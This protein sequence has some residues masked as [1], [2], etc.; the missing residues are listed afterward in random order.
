MNLLMKK[1]IFNTNKFFKD[2]KYVR[3]QIPFC[4]RNKNKISRDIEKLE[5]FPNYKVKFRYLSKIR[6]E[7][8]GTLK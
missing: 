8:N 6:K 3:S 2:S 7:R 5:M 1:K 4:K